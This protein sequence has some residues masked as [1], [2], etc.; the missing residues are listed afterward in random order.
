MRVLDANV[1]LRF[2][3]NDHAEHGATARELMGRLSRAEEVV[4]LPDVV[5]ADIVWTLTSHYGVAKAE[6]RRLLEPFLQL[7]AVRAA[8][9]SRLL[10]ALALFAEQN[11][12][13]SDA[14]VAAEM[15]AGPRREIYSFDRDFDRLPGITRVEP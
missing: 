2:L 4:Y 6:T 14:L 7:D 1:V 8:S 3:L 12:D 9:T 13:F 10:T 11:V 5:L 15:L